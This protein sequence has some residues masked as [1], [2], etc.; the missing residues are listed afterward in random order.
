MSQ[1]VDGELPVILLL[2]WWGAALG[3][4]HKKRIKG[5]YGRSVK[6]DNKDILKAKFRFTLSGK[7]LVGKLSKKIKFRGKSF[8][9]RAR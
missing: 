8:K 1:Y 9:A 4:C 5:Y 7:D 6:V 3:E 2:W